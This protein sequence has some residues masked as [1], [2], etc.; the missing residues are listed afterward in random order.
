T[1]VQTGNRSESRTRSRPVEKIRRRWQSLT[2]IGASKE[3]S[4][5]TR[6]DEVDSAQA[7]Q[8]PEN[9]L[10]KIPLRIER[11]S[12][13]QVLAVPS[14]ISRFSEPREESSVWDEFYDFE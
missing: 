3:C 7:A 12:E 4:L 5:P 1:S 8:A 13:S 14:A 9:R 6:T 2:Q 11:N 10:L